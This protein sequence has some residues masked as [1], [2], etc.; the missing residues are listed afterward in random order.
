MR[1]VSPTEA[2]TQRVVIGIVVEQDANPRTPD[3]KAREA[4]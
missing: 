2:L 4:S 1:R 3:L